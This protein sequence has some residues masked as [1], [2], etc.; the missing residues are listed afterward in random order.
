[1]WGQVMRR[2]GDQLFSAGLRRDQEEVAV[3]VA[4]AMKVRCRDGLPEGDRGAGGRGGD[5]SSVDASLCWGQSG[6]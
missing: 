2:D 1:M 5:H 3:T 6:H 4:G